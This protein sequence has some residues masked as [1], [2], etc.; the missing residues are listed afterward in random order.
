M[1]DYIVAFVVAIVVANVEAFFNYEYL[2]E[3]GVRESLAIRSAFSMLTLVCAWLT[4]SMVCFLARR[5][6][7]GA[8]PYIIFNSLLYFTGFV[9]LL[10]TAVV[11]LCLAFVKHKTTETTE[12]KDVEKDKGQ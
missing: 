1:K 12:T 8:T 5:K 10:G 3:I 9:G 7:V 4:G 11:V 2:V 6:N